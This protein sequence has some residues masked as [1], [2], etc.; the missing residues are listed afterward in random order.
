MSSKEL[1]EALAHRYE[2]ALEAIGDAQRIVV[3]CGAG[4]SLSRTNLGWNDLL[5]QVYDGISRKRI[6]NHQVKDLVHSCTDVVRDSKVPALAR[7]SIL[8]GLIG[9]ELQDKDQKASEENIDRELRKSVKNCL[10]KNNSS[11]N[12]PISLRR[13]RV[14]LLSYLVN[15]AVFFSNLNKNITIVTTNY[16]TYIEDE[17][18][19]F[20]SNH[21]DYAVRIDPLPALEVNPSTPLW[22]QKVL[23]IIYLHGR[24]PTYSN[25]HSNR[26]QKAFGPLVFDESDYSASRALTHATLLEATKEADCLLI[27][28]SSLEDPPLLEFLHVKRRE[29]SANGEDKHLRTVALKSLDPYAVHLPR[30]KSKELLLQIRQQELRYKRIGIEY[31]VPFRTFSEVPLFLRDAV[32]GLL[33]A[34]TNTPTKVSTVGHHS[35]VHLADYCHQLDISLKSSQMTRQLS[36]ILASIKQTVASE[37][38]RAEPP[39]GHANLMLKIELWLRG[40]GKAHEHVNQVVRVLDSESIL[41][42]N[43]TARIED[44]YRRFSSR[45]AAVRA[46]Q[47]GQAK[48]ERLEALGESISASRWQAFFSSPIWTPPV[49]KDPLALLGI[50]VGALVICCGLEEDKTEHITQEEKLLFQ[51]WITGLEKNSPTD[52]DRILNA[53]CDVTSDLLFHA[54]I[55][56]T[57]LDYARENPLAIH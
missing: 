8:K 49:T 27:L 12:K 10:Y 48:F 31:Y 9:L 51:R 15:M 4:V 24:V 2:S 7:A 38:L 13:S 6:P 16:D 54:L 43:S 37:I 36:S 29:R 19:V 41:L 3:Y 17:V 57:P 39:L 30:K 5:N 11:T 28:G 32:V 53:F 40:V 35:Q 26:S 56:T 21:K 18:R 44:Y 22:E 45:T 23:P 47:F 52:L 55:P 46:M 50:P 34:T 25:N 1:R 20:C 33:Q 42:D 14:D